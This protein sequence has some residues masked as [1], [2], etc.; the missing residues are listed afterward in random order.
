[1]EL[2][3]THAHL[4]DHALASQLSAVL[5]RARDAKVPQIIAIGTSAASSR[6]CV[7][8]ASQHAG[9]FA[10][11]GIQ[12]NHCSEVEPGDWDAIVTMARSPKVV[13]VGE[14]GL[15]CYWNDVPFDVQRDYFDRHLRLSQDTGL[16]F[17]VHMRETDKPGKFFADDACVTAI[18]DMLTAA[19]NR[20]ELAGVMHSY[21]GTASRVEAFV[22]LGM[23]VSF[24][25]MLTFK[26]SEALRSAAQLV[27]L[28]RLL[29]ETDSPYLSPE[30][31]RGRRPNEPARVVHTATTLAE[32]RGI[33]LDDLSRQTTAN[34]RRLFRLPKVLHSSRV[35]SNDSDRID[36]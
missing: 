4:D 34:A 15:D 3:D 14:T 2:I 7:E 8:L 28:D 16:P 5:D 32:I 6:R 9:V 29:V 13:A 33:T 18:L 12:P 30:P 17:I 20:G 31:F 21:T 36:G 22:S 26:K 11:V 35:P 10:A 27:P 19:R 1:M 25:G 24:A 23:Y